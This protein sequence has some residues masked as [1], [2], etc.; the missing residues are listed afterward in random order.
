MLEKTRKSLNLLATN[1]FF[2]YNDIRFVG[3][4]ALSHLINHRLSEDLDFAMLD[5]P[6]EEIIDMMN[7][8]G[9]TRKKHSNFIIDSAIN[10]GSDIEDSHIMFD[11]NGVKVDFFEPPFNIKEKD[12]WSNEQYS[13]YN[14]TN[15]KIA[16]FDT[17]MYMKTMAFWNRKKYRDLYDVYYV[18]QNKLNGY[19]ATKFTE[20]YIEYNITHTKEFLLTKIQCKKSFYEKDDDEGINTLVKNPKPYEWYRNKIED[21]LNEV[22]LKELYN[23]T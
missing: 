15:I 8:F 11:L 23:N 9:A 10:D 22:Y 19:T 14:E 16:S 5:F 21:M 18:L 7:S 4:T 12:I 3:G 17:I 1:D 20:K 6:K 2:K 13:L